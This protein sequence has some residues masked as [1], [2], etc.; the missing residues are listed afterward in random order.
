MKIAVLHTLTNGGHM[1]TLTPIIAYLSE[2]DPE[3]V[4][5]TLFCETKDSGTLQWIEWWRGQCGVTTIDVRHFHHFLEKEGIEADFDFLI[6]DTDDEPLIQC[7]N[8]KSRLL[9]I[10]HCPIDRSGAAKRLAIRTFEPNE[11]A[12]RDVITPTFVFPNMT[13]SPRSRSNNRSRAKRMVMVGVH[14][15]GNDWEAVKTLATARKDWKLTIITRSMKTIPDDVCIWNR[16]NMHINFVQNAPTKV[17]INTIRQCDVVVVPKLGAYIYQCI[18]G[19]IGIALSLGIPVVLPHIMAIECFGENYEKEYAG[20][21]VGYDYSAG[22]L[23]AH[24]LGS[25]CTWPVPPHAVERASLY[26]PTGRTI[27][28]AVTEANMLENTAAILRVARR[29][30]EQLTDH[31][32]SF[33]LQ[34]KVPTHPQSQEPHIA[35]LHSLAYHHEMLSCYVDFIRK[36]QGPVRHTLFLGKDSG[37]WSSWQ[38]LFEHCLGPLPMEVIRLPSNDLEELKQVITRHY[39]KFDVWI[40]PTDDDPV[41]SLLPRRDNLI[42]F[43]H[44]PNDRSGA[45][46]R[47]AIRQFNPLDSTVK[48][49]FM[50]TFEFADALPPI[51]KARQYH[52]D[53]TRVAIVGMGEIRN[54]WRSIVE[55]AE[56]DT[57]IIT[58]I[59]RDPILP[60]KCITDR[61]LLRKMVLLLNPPTWKMFEVIRESDVLL[62]P[63]CSSYVHHAMSGSVPIALSL[64]VPVVVPHIMATSCFGVHYEQTSHQSIV[65]YALPADAPIENVDTTVSYPDAIGDTAVEEENQEWIIEPNA[66]AVADAIQ[67]AAKTPRSSVLKFRKEWVNRTAFLFHHTINDALSKRGI[68]LLRDLHNDDGLECSDN[69]LERVD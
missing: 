51:T 42:V 18:S 17:M 47:L 54:D 67:R 57:C 39:P 31:L 63:K 36:L 19:S 24:P 7:M 15:N 34:A 64:G 1:E 21:L 69:D 6:S 66:Y 2:K 27:F 40:A 60:Y 38:Y 33:L 44:S 68:P 22:V 61:S 62:F 26:T 3:C 49:V 35:V 37:D 45:E 13:S 30:F 4:S 46:Y 9:V 25:G 5:W 41:V 16:E 29:C 58:L 56:T 48:G 32:D 10:D 12:S 8:D 55:L 11:D 53:K 14:E 50:C 65:G 43:D 23:D 52:A 28:N 20:A 59:C